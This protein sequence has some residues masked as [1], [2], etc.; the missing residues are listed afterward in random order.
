MAIA[1]T[2]TQIGSTVTVGGGGAATISFSSIPATYT[3]LKIL[4]SLKSPATTAAYEVFGINFNNST[5][6]QGRVLYYW[7]GTASTGS[8]TTFTKSGTTYGRVFDTGFNTLS[9]TYVNPN[10]YSST[11]IYITNY[12]GGTNYKVYGA[13]NASENN[14]ASDGGFLELAAGLSSNAAAITTITVTG[15]DY[16]FIQYSTA[17]LYGILKA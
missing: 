7:F 8:E 12:A 11:E 1:N 6:Y 14:S 2:F 4:L 5:S 10:I 3:D 13:A 16:G 15:R 9:T 17:S